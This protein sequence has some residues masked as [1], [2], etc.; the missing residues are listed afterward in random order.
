ML[1]FD[2]VARRL[3]GLPMFVILMLVIE[4]IDEFAFG[5]LEAALPRIRTDLGLSYDQVGLLLTLPSVLANVFFEPLI[6]I[7]GDTGRRRTLVLLGGIGFALAAFFVATS[8]T[9]LALMLAL[10]LFNP[11]SGAL[12][13]LGQAS[14]MDYD[15]AR[16]EYNMA[17][18][19]FAGSVGVVIG[20]SVIS[21]LLA[22]SVGWRGFY[23]IV[24]IMTVIMLMWLRRVR[25][26]KRASESEDEDEEETSQGFRETLRSV[27]QAV[28]RGEVLRWLTLLQLSDLMLDAL[29]AY[30]GLY[31]VDVIGFT[32]AQAALAVTVWT[33]VG[34]VGDL[35]LIPLLQRIP[36]LVYLRF[37]AAIEFVLYSAFLFIPS[38]PVK[39]VLIGIIGFFNAGWYAIL[40]ANLYQAMP[41]L[42]GSVMTLNTLFG[43]FSSVVPLLIGLIAERYGLPTAMLF[44]L[45]A[46]VGVFV[47]LPFRQLIPSENEATAQNEI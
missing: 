5:G 26:I 19:T 28:R 13:G 4:F 29:H 3:R 9:Y 18:W 1:R 25:F 2:L 7:L 20:G 34:L 30:L 23:L 40:Q 8:Q 33:T 44:P 14:L 37:S 46:C 12:V 39:L 31:F 47:G 6:G 21:V 36:G 35:A 45:I 43:L 16:S 41:G 11:S 15:P 10:I 24:A 42:S 27:L 17:R 32:E 22:T 38:I